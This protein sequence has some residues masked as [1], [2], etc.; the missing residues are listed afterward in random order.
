MHEGN[1]DDAEHWEWDD[2]NERELAAHGV[3]PVEVEEVW[4][5]GGPIMKNKK[6]G[7]AGW[8]M[9]GRTRG[10]RALSIYFNYDPVRL[11]I[12]TVTGWDSPA[13]DRSRYLGER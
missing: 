11:S 8:K 1:P 6:G 5:R 7:S 4:E 12:R 13:G 3:A 9:V 10:G 2:G